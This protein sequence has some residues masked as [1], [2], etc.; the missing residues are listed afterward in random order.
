MSLYEEQFDPDWDSLDRDEAMV[1]AFALGVAASMG[2][3]HEE[4]F[5]AVQ[6]EMG[7]NY[8]ASIVEL[9]YKE[10]KGK[11]KQRMQEIDARGMTLWRK[12]LTEEFDAELIGID[13]EWDVDA[14]ELLK[15]AVQ[16]PTDFPSAVADRS[17]AIDRPDPDPE[18]TEFPD[19]LE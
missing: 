8:D 11:T 19:F 12:L 16:R 6:G 4:E 1:R 9:A 7:T 3:P 18:Q 5:E 13:E 17:E 14:V 15:D 2:E 10:G